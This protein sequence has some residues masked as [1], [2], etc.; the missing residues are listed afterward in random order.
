MDAHDLLFKY[1]FFLSNHNISEDSLKI[2]ADF[3][4]YS[5][6]SVPCKIANV[7]LDLSFQKWE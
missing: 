5:S 2:L 1:E 4:A 6:V 3:L 7:Y